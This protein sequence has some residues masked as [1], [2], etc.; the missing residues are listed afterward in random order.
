MP[1]RGLEP[2]TALRVGRAS[3]ATGDMRVDGSPLQCGT[4]RATP[5]RLYS[6]YGICCWSHTIAIAHAMSA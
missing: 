3:I 5:A 2:A 1:G 4:N 6:F